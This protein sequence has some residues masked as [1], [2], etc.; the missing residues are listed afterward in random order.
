[1]T[2]YRVIQ[3]DQIFNEKVEQGFFRTREKARERIELL[4][5]FDKGHTPCKYTIEIIEVK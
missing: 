1:M 4:K 3:R 5:Q 2:I